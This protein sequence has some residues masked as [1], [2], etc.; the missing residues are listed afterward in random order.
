MSIKENVEK[1]VENIEKACQKSG[2]KPEDVKILGATKEVTSSKIRKAFSLGI[3][4]FG[5][6]RVQEAMKKVEELNDLNIEWHMIGT[7]QRNKVKKAIEIF[8]LL[9]SISS[10]K[11]ALEVDKEAGKKGII[12][13]CFLEVNLGMEETKSGFYENELLKNLE[14]LSELSNIKIIGLMTIPPFS[15]NPEDSRRYFVRLRELSVKIN[16]LRTKILIKEL[17]MGMSNDYIVAVEEGAT[18]VRLGTA[19]FGERGKS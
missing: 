15:Q 5:E 2:R 3:R 13:P 1:I 9:E 4:L 6:N 10:V 14:N 16:S 17:S 8:N 19:I 12:V 11:L 18:I 7:L